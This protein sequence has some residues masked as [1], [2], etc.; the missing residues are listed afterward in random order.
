MNFISQIMRDI[1]KKVIPS[2]PYAYPTRASYRPYENLDVFNIWKEE[3]QHTTEIINLYIHFP[4]C[5]YKCGFCNLYSIA[6]SDITLQT[7]YIDALIKQIE[8]YADIISSRKIKTIF[9]GGGTPMFLSTENFLKIIGVLDRISPSWPSEVEEFCIE[10]SP[11]SVLQAAQT[12]QLNCLLSNGINRINIGIQSFKENDIKV[13]GRSYSDNVNVLAVNIM[14]EYGIQNISTDL[15]AGFKGQSFED[16][17]FSVQKMVELK[18]H[19]ISAYSLRVRPDSIFG[20]NKR[21]IKNPPSIY[22]EWYEA[23][24]KIILKDNYRQETNVRYTMLENGGYRQQDYQFNSYPVL[25]IGAGARSYT[26]VADYIIGGGYPATEAQINN[27]IEGANKGNLKIEKAFVLTD[28]ERIRRML[29]LN[30]Y[31]FDLN[32]VHKKYGDKYDELFIE[33]FDGLI[34]N[35]LLKKDGS[36]YSLTYEGIKYRDII[37]WS[38]F[39]NEVKGLDKDFYTNI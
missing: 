27:Y 15:I 13:M 1:E 17:I 25:G 7:K 37:S 11:D 5:K 23:A 4:F 36:V 26:S 10:A 38:F 3:K 30:L 16:W 8:S 14:K 9:L 39:S 24:R 20:Q 19:T 12:D 34:K 33:P 22:Y 6:S 21:E 28:Q 31:R 18:P 29:V 32:T 35:D 2:Y